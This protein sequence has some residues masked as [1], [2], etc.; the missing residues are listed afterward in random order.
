[1]PSQMNLIFRD[2]VWMIQL[3]LIP[4]HGSNFF[5]ISNPNF[6]F[7]KVNRKLYPVL[8]VSSHRVHP[9][10]SSRRIEWSTREKQIDIT[11][12]SEIECPN[13]YHISLFK[14]LVNNNMNTIFLPHGHIL[15][16]RLMPWSYDNTL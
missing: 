5:S 2:L 15:N 12:V 16:E 6:I 7:Y 1:M 11:K 10:I 3:D 9:I 13:C 8:C 14:H 4:P